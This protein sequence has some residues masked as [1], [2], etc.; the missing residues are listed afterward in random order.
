MEIRDSEYSFQVYFEF[1]KYERFLSV[2]LINQD[3]LE[4]ISR[5]NC[6]QIDISQTFLFDFLLKNCNCVIGLNPNDTL[7]TTACLRY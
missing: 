4:N 7:N 1:L 2:L 5:I 6:Y 3:L